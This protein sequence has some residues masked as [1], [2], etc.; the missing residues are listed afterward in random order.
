LRPGGI[1]GAGEKVHF[2]RIRKL[3]QLGL[4]YFLISPVVDKNMARQCL[5]SHIHIFINILNE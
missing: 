2:E 5:L 3:A 1:Y 4:L